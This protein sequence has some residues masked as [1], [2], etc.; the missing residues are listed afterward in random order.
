MRPGLKIVTLFEVSRNG[1]GK[2]P[3]NMITLIKLIIEA[4]SSSIEVLQL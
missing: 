1:H 4:A 3:D 2:V